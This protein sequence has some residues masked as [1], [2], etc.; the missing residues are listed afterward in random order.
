MDKIVRASLTEQIF[1]SLKEKIVAGKWKAGDK[2]PSET[3]LAETLGVS[4][5]SVRM[6][7]QKLNALGMTETRV[8][9]GTFV[10][11]VSLKPYFSELLRLNQIHSDFR[12][13]H[14]FYRALE[15]S[16]VELALRKGVRKADIALLEKIYEEM[17]A[18]LAAD[19]LDLFDETDMRFHMTIADM[20]HNQLFVLIYDAISNILRLTFRESTRQIR[21]TTGKYDRVLEYHRELLEG[22]KN[23]D[24]QRCL[25][26]EELA[27]RKTKVLWPTQEV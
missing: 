11:E 25:R 19:R 4:R 14:E 18:N 10:R 20:T 7:I 26:A 21:T 27:F 3:E 22:I 1:D 9:E 8:G 5:I 23:N 13:I 12:T 6:A 16:C 2:L 15:R 24:W 17:E